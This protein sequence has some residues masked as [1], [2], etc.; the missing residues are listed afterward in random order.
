MCL[1]IRTIHVCEIKRTTKV[2]CVPKIK[3]ADRMI[4]NQCLRISQLLR[5]RNLVQVSRMGLN[6]EVVFSHLQPASTPVVMDLTLGAGDT[7]RSLLSESENL[8]VIAVDCD[9]DSRDTMRKLEF[10]FGERISSYLTR[11]SGLPEIM[12][13]EG[14][15]ETCDAIVMELGPSRI[16]KENVR[17]GFDIYIDGDLDK[18]YDQAGVNCAQ[19]IK[20][21][22]VDNL[23]K[24][25]RYYGGVIKAK[26]IAS[27]LVERRYMLQEISTIAHLNQVLSQ[28]HRQDP[29]WNE[30][31]PES[32]DDNI[33]HVHLA[34]R[35]FTNDEINE[36]Q[37]SIKMAE[38]VLKEG[39]ILV[40]DAKSEHEREIATK[41]LFRKAGNS[42][43][44][45]SEKSIQ[46]RNLWENEY[47]DGSTIVFRKL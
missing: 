3:F 14:E 15:T 9:P 7:S 36:L 18:R 30:R 32:I 37:F 47:S 2:T 40:L 4:A 24:I 22:D 10:D 34:L 21:T 26:N 8:R 17:R 29:F 42:G 33:Q 44:S 45:T 38:L 11:W 5:L 46:M 20:F 19:V 31:G 1:H 28:I 25:L 43:Q 39:G 35:M 12:R 27:E 13:A 6:T 41:F 23:R 16:Q